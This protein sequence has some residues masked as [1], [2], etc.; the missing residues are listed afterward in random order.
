[1][2]VSRDDVRHIAALAR[3]GLPE[4]RIDALVKELSGILDHMDVLAKVDTSTAPATDAGPMPLAP[5][6]PRPV[7]LNRPKETFAPETRDGFF[8]VPR[9]A[10]HED[11]EASS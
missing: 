4:S 9:L 11:G 5:D 7:A 10:T 2:S 3:I 1:M 6:E 8:L